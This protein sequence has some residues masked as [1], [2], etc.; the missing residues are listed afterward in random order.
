MRTIFDEVPDIC[1]SEDCDEPVQCLIHFMPG[2]FL[3]IQYLCL[4]HGTDVLVVDPSV[5]FI[6]FPDVEIETVQ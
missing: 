2:W 5:Q 6:V 4:T 1:E 3:P